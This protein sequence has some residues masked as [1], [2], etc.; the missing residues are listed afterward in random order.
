MHK[1]FRVNCSCIFLCF[2]NIIIYISVLLLFLTISKQV[3]IK[4]AKGTGKKRKKRKTKINI[5]SS[6]LVKYFIPIPRFS[7]KNFK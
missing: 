2:N 5:Q 6:F 4:T 3:A 1:K 7:V